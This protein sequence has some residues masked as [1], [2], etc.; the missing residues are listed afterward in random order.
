M[1]K[2][3][4]EKFRKEEG[5]EGS[6]IRKQVRD[7]LLK[8][9]E[10]GYKYDDDDLRWRHIGYYCEGDKKYMVMFDLADL[11]KLKVEEKESLAQVVDS[12]IKLLEARLPEYGPE[13]QSEK[14]GAQNA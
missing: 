2:R 7:C 3:D 1:E 9:A 4:R 10:N 11:V 12:Q 8:L 6:E 14:N 13:G 5:K